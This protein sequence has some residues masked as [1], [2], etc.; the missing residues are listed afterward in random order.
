MGFSET[1]VQWLTLVP[2]MNPMKYKFCFLVNNNEDIGPCSVFQLWAVNL[3]V[4]LQS[5]KY[6]CHVILYLYSSLSTLQ[7]AN[8]YFKNLTGISLNRRKNI[9]ISL[10]NTTVYAQTRDK[11]SLTLSRSATNI[12]CALRTIA[13]VFL[14]NI[15][16]AHGRCVERIQQGLQFLL[17][18]YLG[19][20]TYMT[21]PK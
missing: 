14:S 18:Q 15:L 6:V 10:Q 19:Q 21:I 20:G 2:A 11:H 17:K 5:E 16:S 4:N 3:T 7:T 12:Q 13:L 1:R 9:L 8:D